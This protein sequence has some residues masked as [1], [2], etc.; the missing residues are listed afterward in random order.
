MASLAS[1]WHRGGST[2]EVILE[3]GSSDDDDFIEQ[4]ARLQAAEFEQQEV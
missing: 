3:E 4:E 1:R 2:V